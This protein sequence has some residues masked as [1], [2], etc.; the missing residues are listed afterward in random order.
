MALRGRPHPDP[1]LRQGREFRLA[2]PL[3]TKERANNWLPLL[4]KERANNWL[5][6]LTKE[7]VGGR[8]LPSPA[9]WERGRG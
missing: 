4:T 6:L 9:A 5:P 1:P 7:G 2:L 3:L 8:S